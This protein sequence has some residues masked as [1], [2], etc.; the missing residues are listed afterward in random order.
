MTRPEPRLLSALLRHHRTRRG[1]TQLD[2]SIAAE[3]SARHISFLETGRATPSAEMLRVLG[4]A[5]DLTLRE[6][7]ELFAAAGLPHAFTEPR[8]D[9]EIPEPIAR[10]IDRMLARHEPYPITVLDRRYDVLRAN[11]SAMRVLGRFI[12]EPSALPQPLNVLT[13]LFDPRLAR[14]FVEDWPSVARNI[15][16]RVQREALVHGGGAGLDALV[17]ELMSYPGVPTSFGAVDL[18]APSDPML[19]LR[20]RRGDLGLSFLATMT[21]FSAPQNVTLEELRIES[22]FPM[23]RDTELTCERLA[24]EG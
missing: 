12:A 21:V 11:P 20:L 2:L 23:D 19:V 7:N 22:Y 14:P 8:F 3:V 16:G 6:Q 17:R 1:L 4:G 10:A 13:A 18:S 24:L 15:L 5:L 9:G